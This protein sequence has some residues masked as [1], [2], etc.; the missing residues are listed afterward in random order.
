MSHVSGHS[1][2]D[3]VGR[4][5]TVQQLYVLFVWVGWAG[6]FQWFCQGLS[7]LSLASSAPIAVQWLHCPF[8]MLPRWCLVAAAEAVAT[9]LLRQVA[10]GRGLSSC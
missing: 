6:H 5:R 8:G 1:S 10:K 7:D 4:Y 9:H 2:C 3:D